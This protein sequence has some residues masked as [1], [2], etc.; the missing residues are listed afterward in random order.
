MLQHQF[1][2]V[3]TNILNYIGSNFF[4]YYFLLSHL[5]FFIN[6]A[7]LTAFFRLDNG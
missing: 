1:D 3:Y 5:M 4:K 2:G 7:K 6:F